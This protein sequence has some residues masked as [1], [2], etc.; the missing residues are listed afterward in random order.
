MDSEK[1]AIFK[2]LWEATG[3][4]KVLQ[5]GL[6]FLDPTLNLKTHFKGNQVA[7]EC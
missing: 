3:F 5:S 2:L 1:E 4:K 7:A 6:S